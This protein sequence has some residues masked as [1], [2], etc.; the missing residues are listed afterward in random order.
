MME[1]KKDNQYVNE[2]V[3]AYYTSWQSSNILAGISQEVILRAVNHAIDSKNEG[4]LISN[5]EVDEYIK[6]LR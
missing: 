5:F 3:S 1:E 6:K 4:T 2:P